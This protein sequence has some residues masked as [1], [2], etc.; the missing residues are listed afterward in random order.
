MKVVKMNDDRTAFVKN[1]REF[2]KD[3]D[4]S[5]VT[6]AEVMAVVAKYEMKRPSWLLKLK[7]GNRGCYFLPTTD[8]RY[9]NEETAIASAVDVVSTPVS[10]VVAMAPRGIE[11]LEEQDSYIPEKFTGYVP[12][13]NFNTLKK[14]IKSEIFYPIF[15]TGMSGN[16]KTLKIG[17]AHV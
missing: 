1:A 6:R 14:V 5:E 3:E 8:G 10:N 17:R 4:R 13:G 16:G 15:I 2:L 9:G 12:W 7:T 11:V